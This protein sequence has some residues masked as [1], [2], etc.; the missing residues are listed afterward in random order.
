[1][2]SQYPAIVEGYR[3]LKDNFI[4][5]VESISALRAL[6]AVRVSGQPE[7]A[8]VDSALETLVRNLDLER[9]SAFVLRE[10]GTLENAGGRDW[11]DLMSDPQGQATAQSGRSFRVGEGLVGRAVETGEPQHCRDCVNDPRFAGKDTARRSPGS[12]VCV[13]IMVDRDVVG[14]LNVSHTHPHFFSESHE[15]TLVIFASFLGQMLHN[16][17]LLHSMDDLVRQR[18]RELEAALA[19]AESLKR[20]Y[21]DLA[22][23]DDLTGLHNRRYFF[24]E[25]RAALAQALRHRAA[26]AIALIDIDH[27]KR[28]NDVHGHAV[29]DEVLKLIAGA[30]QQQ[31][32]EEDILA[33]FGG[34]EFVLALPQTDGRGAMVLAERIRAR[35]GERSWRFADSEVRV[36]V[37]IGISALE[38]RHA[39][40]KEA[41]LDLMLGEADRALYVGKRNGRDQTRLF[42]DLPD[43]ADG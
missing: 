22:V 5:L 23:M 17:R 41:L 35:L 42:A 7:H 37:S 26:F 20:R 25:A 15:R 21:A 16:N 14:V 43:N 13:P 12:L 28:I 40:V 27:F 34:E 18:T 33:R 4:T 36:S 30:L 3:E 39:T 9:C 8:L 6:S 32:R 11:N 2:L 24:P 10:D 1:M 19:E 38:S 31:L 29:G